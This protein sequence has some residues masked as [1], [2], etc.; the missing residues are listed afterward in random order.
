MPNKDSPGT[1]NIKTENTESASKNQLVKVESEEI[2]KTENEIEPVKLK[3]ENEIKTEG[4]PEK[5][6]IKTQNEDEQN[7]KVD[8]TSSP[9]YVIIT[10]INYNIFIAVV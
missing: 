8:V 5:K 4:S 3:S 2:K 6:Y 10:F 1:L 9:G 7:V